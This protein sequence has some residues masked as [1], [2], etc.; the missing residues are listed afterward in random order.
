MK[1]YARAGL[2][3]S[4]DRPVTFSLAGALRRLEFQCQSR[5][6][7]CHNAQAARRALA[8]GRGRGSRRA[9]GRRALPG[10]G[11]APES[12]PRPGRGPA[13]DS[14]MMVTSQ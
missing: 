5:R 3:S 12:G 7:T 2:V 1:P 8:R 11:D 14:M 9:Q 13:V 4:S 10:A 6:R